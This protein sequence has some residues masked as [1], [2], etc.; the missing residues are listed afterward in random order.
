MQAY[1]R[2]MQRGDTHLVLRPDSDFFRY[3]GNPSGKEAPAGTPAPAATNP[4]ASK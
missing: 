3:F 2:S 1:E 4:P